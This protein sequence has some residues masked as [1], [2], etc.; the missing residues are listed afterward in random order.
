MTHP[1]I[2][3]YVLQQLMAGGQRG[4]HGRFA[5]QIVS[6][7]NDELV[8]ILPLQTVDARAKARM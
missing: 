1:F 3:F 7:T 2:C 8:L 5:A 6:T 4:P